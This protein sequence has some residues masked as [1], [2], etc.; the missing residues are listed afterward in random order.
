MNHLNSK[1]SLPKQFMTSVN[2][3]KSVLNLP[4]SI[5]KNELRKNN[6]LIEDDSSNCIDEKMLERFAELYKKRLKRYF[7]SSVK[8][9]SKLTVEEYSDFVDFCKTFSKNSSITFNWRNIDKDTIQ[10]VFFSEIKKAAEHVLK[11]KLG[12]EHQAAYIDALVC[13]SLFSLSVIDVKALASDLFN[14][15]INNDLFS[16]VECNYHPQCFNQQ[17]LVLSRVKRNKYYRCRIT[18]KIQCHPLE[19]K[20]HRKFFACLRWHIIPDDGNSD[21]EIIKIA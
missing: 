13:R 9:F 18:R 3:V 8:N 10:E 2:V 5:V 14:N 21:D 12:S 1:Y 11:F 7:I 17:I 4:I 20:L 16:Y 6:Y 15:R 19:R